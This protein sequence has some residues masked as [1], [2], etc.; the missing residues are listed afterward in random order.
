MSDEGAGAQRAQQVP[1]PYRDAQ[2]GETVHERRG[3]HHVVGVALPGR[4]LDPRYR[5]LAILR[6]AIV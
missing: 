6:T 2:D 1:D 5:E 4:V 3:A